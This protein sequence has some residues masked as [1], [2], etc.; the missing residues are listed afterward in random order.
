MK[1]NIFSISCER[2]W[3]LWLPLPPPR[4][5]LTPFFCALWLITGLSL[6]FLIKASG[7][8]CVRLTFF[9]GRG[10]VEYKNNNNNNDKK[11]K[12]KRHWKQ[13]T[14]AVI[15]KKSQK[16]NFIQ[17]TDPSAT[18]SPLGFCVCRHFAALF[19]DAGGPQFKIKH[20]V[21]SYQVGRWLL[22]FKE[23]FSLRS[24]LFCE[25]IGQWAST[26]T[27]QCVW[28]EKQWHFT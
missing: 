3:L 13:S 18:V 28:H 25:L 17:N 6:G 5:L 10:G 9:S 2:H 15:G 24:S 4:L 23:T 26:R 12:E 11:W 7:T 14:L 21:P 8:F 27:I 16:R 19:M 1:E 22:S 20:Q